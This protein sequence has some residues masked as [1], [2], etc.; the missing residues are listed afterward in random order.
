MNDLV[1]YLD[2]IGVAE[3]TYLSFR[4]MSAVPRFSLPYL[5]VYPHPSPEYDNNSLR[6]HLLYLT[7]VY[8][9]FSSKRK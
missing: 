5:F 8:A 4:L 3:V 1:F 9:M 2:G 7:R 6:H